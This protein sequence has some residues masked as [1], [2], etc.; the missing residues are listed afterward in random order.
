MAAYAAHIPPIEGRVPLMERP[1][2]VVLNK[3]DVPDAQE[4]AD[5]VHDE[6]KNRGLAVFAVS[7]VSRVGLREL[8]YALGT[9]VEHLRAQEVVDDEVRPVIRPLDK[10][11]DSSFTI[12]PRQQD[13][14]AF[15]QVRGTKPERWVRQTD[16]SN[17][18]AVGYLAD[19]L[20]NLGIEKELMKIGA[21]AGDMV[22]IGS[23]ED[24]MIFDW[25]P[26]MA[27]GAELL[28]PR[29][30]DIRLDENIRPTRRERK[31]QYYEMMDAK[32]AARQELWTERQ[33][34]IWTDPDEELP[35][36]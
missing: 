4:L 12:T 26:T 18:E 1:R 20:N 13:E 17:D 2:I 22:V 3:I 14:K 15:Y 32:E 8:G 10:K 23:V 27:T 34:G 28:S 11:N 21:R 30:T 24:G 19:R 33:A 7:A 29:G 6:L 9:I 16:F 35:T 31:S 5:F 36:E 25:E